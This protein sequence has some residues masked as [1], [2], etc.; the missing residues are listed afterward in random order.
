MP[1]FNDLPRAILLS[2][3]TL[4]GESYRDLEDD[5]LKAELARRGFEPDRSALVNVM[6]QLQDAGYLSCAFT[7][8]GIA[9]IRL[10]HAGRQE[11]ESWPVMPGHPT[12][13][14]VEALLDTLLARS[15]DPQVPEPDRGKARAAAAAL[16]DLGVSVTGEIIAAWLKHLG[17]G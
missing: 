1:Q 13:S 5:E 2:V 4:S 6:H 16:R 14:D 9:L 3:S 11:V 10:E 15:E 12:T 7:G 8:T 17:V